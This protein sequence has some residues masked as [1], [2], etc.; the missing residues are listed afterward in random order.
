[1]LVWLSYQATRESQ[2]S[3]Q[4]LL[5][6]NTTAQLALLMAGLAQDMKGAHASVLVPLGLHEPVLEP[7]YDLAETVAR[8]FARFP[9]PESFFVWNDGGSD[10]GLTYLFNRADRLPVWLDTTEQ[11][12]SPYPVEIVRD[13]VALSGLVATARLRERDSGPFAVFET[14]VGGV[15]YQVVANLRYQ[16]SRQDEPERLSG[17]VGFTVN[18]DWVRE[19]YFHELILQI[20]RIG[21][22]PGNVSLA[23][24]DESDRIVASTGPHGPSVTM[25]RAFPFI[26][27]DRSLI[28]VLPLSDRDVLAWTARASAVPGSPLAA[29]AAGNKSPIVLISLAAFAA[30]VGLLA[31]TRAARVGLELAGMKADFVASVTH[32]LKTPLALI[33]LIADTLAGGRI[34]SPKDIRDYATMLSHE[35]KDLTR[36]IDNLLA[37][38]RLGDVEHAYNFEPVDVGDV[39]DDALEFFRALLVEKELRV[40]VG[41]PSDLPPVRADRAA[42]ILLLNNLIDNAIKYSKGKPVLRIRAHQVD[43][44]IVITVA[45]RGVGIRDDEVE[46]VCDKFFR[47]REVT[48]GGSG[49]GLA[50]VRQIVEAHRGRLNIDSALGQGTRVDVSLPVSAAS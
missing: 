22:E 38:G 11:L 47:G 5:E 48:T 39:V 30:M 17:L 37:Y 2:S 32:E 49:L 45:D 43:E 15:P 25:E 13:P 46:R 1:M 50:I 44:S 6:Q 31:T 23:I 26:F 14:D 20:A 33:R 8:G 40:D 9:Y 35:S 16:P 42:L 3:A 4:L 28:G 27:L 19:V 12:A 36:L 21:G 18:L 34:D 29:A 7:P 24:L 10:N 41:F